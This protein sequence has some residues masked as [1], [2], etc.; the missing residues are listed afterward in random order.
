M[1]IL[2]S[3]DKA[4]LESAEKATKAE[5]SRMLHQN[6]KFLAVNTRTYALVC[7]RAHLQLNEQIKRMGS[8]RGEEGEWHK[9]TMRAAFYACFS[10]ARTHAL[11]LTYGRLNAILKFEAG[12][13]EQPVPWVT[14]THDRIAY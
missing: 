11:R 6:V 7:I 12:P 14:N 13:V 9:S 2:E 5:F 3:A 10:T 1:D 8:K 4:R